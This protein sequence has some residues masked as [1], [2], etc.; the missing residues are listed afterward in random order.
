MWCFLVLALSERWE[1]KAEIEWLKGSARDYCQKGRHVTVACVTIVRGGEVKTYCSDGIYVDESHKPVRPRAGVGRQC[2]ATREAKRSCLTG[3]TLPRCHSEIAALQ[4]LFDIPD[5]TEASTWAD[6]IKSL[7]DS[8]PAGPRQD[9]KKADPKIQ[10]IPRLFNGELTGIY[11]SLYNSWHAPCGDDDDDEKSER[12]PCDKFLR[13]VANKV[14]E[15]LQKEPE[16][17]RRFF[18]IEVWYPPKDKSRGEVGTVAYGIVPEHRPVITVNGLNAISHGV[19]K[20]H[21]KHKAANRGQ[22]D[23]IN[24][25]LAVLFA[26]M[27]GF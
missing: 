11:V 18:G 23:N 13:E 19:K 5:G 26:F 9:E 24:V 2:V 14:N 21:R 20:R 16:K 7:F 17:G 4:D 6:K 10:P 27:L 15:R 3:P 22:M 12:V 8:T 1:E 25:N